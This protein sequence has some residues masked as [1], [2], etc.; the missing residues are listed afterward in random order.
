LTLLKHLSDQGIQVIPGGVNS[1]IDMVKV[2]NLVADVTQ[3]VQTEP[4][5]V[6]NEKPADPSHAV[7]NEKAPPVA[8]EAERREKGA[9]A[10]AD[11]AKESDPDADV[12]PDMAIHYVIRAEVEHF[13]SWLRSGEVQRPG[14]RKRTRS[15]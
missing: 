1:V 11:T 7:N 6:E 9:N 13:L 4:C 10:S 14:L 5:S 8:A 3:N 2:D 15:C 12:S